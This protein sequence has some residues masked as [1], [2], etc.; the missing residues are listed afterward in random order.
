MIENFFWFTE[1]Q[2]EL[3]KR[4]SQFV[5][6]N[7]EE[8]EEYF[9]NT[10]FPWPLVKKVAKEGYFG[11]GVP[12]KYGGLELGATG[13]CIAAE[14]LGRLY[15]VGHVFT[16][17]MLAGLEQ[18]LR[19]ANE[20]QRE[21]WLPKI[22]SGEELGALCITEP[23]AGSDAANIFT[24]AEK[25]GDEWIING[26]K[27]Y[28]TGAGVSD[29][30][31]IYA[32]T[33]D[34]KSLRKQYAHLTSFVV[35]KGRPG[36]SLEKVN[37]L[38]GFDNVPNGYLDFDNVRIPDENRIGEV[39]KGWNVM[40]AGLNFERLIGAAVFGGLFEDIISLIFYYT[41]R[42]VQ[43]N[44]TTIQFPGIQN[45]IADIIA[46]A[47]LARLFSYHCAK[48]LDDGRE[49]MIEASIAKMVN[50]EFVRDI[51]IKAIQVLG[52]DGLT[53]FLPVERILREAKVG[54]I[55][56]G[57]T[58]IQK[59]IIYRFSAM[60]PIYNKNIRLR[61]NDTVNAPIISKKQSKFK[62]LVVN[63]ENVLKVIA[64]DYKVNPGLYMTPDDVR[65]DIGG[66]RSA[67][68]DVFEVL[69]KKNLIVCHRD[70][71]DKVVLVKA[72]YL[73]LQK[74]FPKEYYQ[75]FPEWYEDSDKF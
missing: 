43:F 46:K 37:P 42:R 23:F 62:G 45:E 32:K 2:K 36:F 75:W 26:K 29:R 68:K 24:T 67:L 66:S 48:L 27:R 70:R 11:V 72:T 30:Y 9:W 4:L 15:A 63:E 52:G 61:W 7:F 49:P 31:F 28:I 50:T 8:A 22:A 56:A 54:E 44:R 13:S 53:K 17:S 55:V 35:E 60:L 6:D 64:H 1:E 57:T 33:S 12:K 58:E 14:Q 20:E 73:G 25:D 71:Q 69:E 18:M 65:E 19:F 59:M 39:G 21:K 40:M 16:V 5:E 47:K 38:I 51:G 10:K 34:D 74:A 3:A 41:K